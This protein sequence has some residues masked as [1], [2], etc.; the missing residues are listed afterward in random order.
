MKK[1]Y[2]KELT[3]LAT[4][5]LFSSVAHAQVSVH[6]DGSSSD[7]SVASGTGPLLV[8]GDTQ[9]TGTLTVQPENVVT[10][11]STDTPTGAGIDPS[12]GSVGPTQTTV[13]TKL[14]ETDKQ[15]VASTGGGAIIQSNGDADFTAST[16]TQTDATFS[17]FTTVDVF[18]A[19]EPDAGQPVPGSQMYFAADAGGT[20]IS[21]MFA[22][23]AD[24]DNWVSTTPL[25][26]PAFTG[27]TTTTPLSGTGG[28]VDVG[29]TLDLGDSGSGAVTDVA[30]V[31]NSNV[32]GVSSNATDIASNNAEI[33]SND[34][35]IASNNAEIVANDT[36]IAS[37]NA[38]IVANDTDI[39]SNNAEIVA[40]D[41]DIASNNAEIVANDT[42]IASNNAE[43]VANDTDIA[44]NNANIVAN[45]TDIASNN[46]K[47]DTEIADRTAL[48][49]QGPGDTIE[50][51][52][53]TLVY[54][55]SD[56]SADRLTSTKSELIIGGNGTT[57]VTV[58]ANLDVA[59]DANFQQNVSIAGD[60]FING[61][62]GVQA[63]LDNLDSR[64]D[65]NARGIAMVAALQNST[66]LPGMTHALDVGAAHFEGET[67]MSLNYS[68]RI[69]ENVQINFGAAST[70]DF[71]E[72]VIRAGV[73][74]QW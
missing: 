39:A 17:R 53:N 61:N 47:I 38:G 65:E 16:G 73:G 45:D 31:I 42:D 60:L 11:T 21:P 72:S 1:K 55:F 74:V 8:D 24:L 10:S 15:E 23:E 41:T 25:S 19:G 54:D 63:Q 58:D 29:G 64:V 2:T 22:T 66:V 56:P 40:N 30:A 69:N 44:S 14:G 51:G 43:I 34:T 62:P 37:N 18:N 20:P 71:D 48:I 3:A 13:V 5:A 49:R 6:P 67:G 52:N 28:N 50:I 36:D 4:L 32:A 46:S 7:P 12:L 33:V 59:G 35:D 57:D 26:D 9:V 68:R 27:L 70:T